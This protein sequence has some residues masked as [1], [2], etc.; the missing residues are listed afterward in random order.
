MDQTVIQPRWNKRV[1][2]GVH[3]SRTESPDAWH[4]PKSPTTTAPYTSL[5][6]C[7][8][9]RMKE[10]VCN[11][12]VLCTCVF[13]IIAWICRQSK[14]WLWH[15]IQSSRCRPVFQLIDFHWGDQFQCFTIPVIL[16]TLCLYC[17]Y[18]N[19]LYI[20]LHLRLYLCLSVCHFLKIL[21]NPRRGQIQPFSRFT[22]ICCW[23]LKDEW[24]CLSVAIVL[25]LLHH[26][27]IINPR[28]E[29]GAR[30]N[31]RA[32]PSSPVWREFSGGSIV[33]AGLVTNTSQSP[34]IGLSFLM[35]LVKFIRCCAVAQHPPPLLSVPLSSSLLSLSPMRESRLPHSLSHVG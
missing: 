33:A 30:V 21:F 6:V 12:V 19:L 14:V 31:K 13:F 29:K 25:F 18:A 35:H 5:R 28:E 22:R 10:C 26:Q 4:D 9:V 20:F 27:R 7:V 8:C 24:G 2:N 32:P 3:L 23:T 16:G 34:L 15:W 1:C 11:G 17:I